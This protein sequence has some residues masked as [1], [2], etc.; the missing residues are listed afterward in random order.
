MADGKRTERT[1][2]PRGDVPVRLGRQRGLAEEAAAADGVCVPAGLPRVRRR[3]P[4]RPAQ[5]AR[6]RL[7]PRH[8]RDAAAAVAR[9]LRLHAAQHR[10][11]GRRLFPLKR[12]QP[13][14]KKKEN[15]SHFHETAPEIGDSPRSRPP[16]RHR[17]PVTVVVTS[18]PTHHRR[19][20]VT[21]D[22]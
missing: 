1:G 5:D 7:L 8:A 19:P 13:T 9:R 20:D 12:R 21:G 3:P 2:G 22:Q 16:R 11:T 10:R 15:D 6:R 4:L 17:R 14:D 18:P